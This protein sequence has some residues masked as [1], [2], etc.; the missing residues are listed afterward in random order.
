MSE[1][2]FDKI[3][4]CTL[5][6]VLVYFFNLKVISD[7]ENKLILRYCWSYWR[8]IRRKMHL[9]RMRKILQIAILFLPLL[10]W[11]WENLSWSSATFLFVCYL[12]FLVVISTFLHFIY[13]KLIMDSDS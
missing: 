3:F 6:L 13:I 10:C 5:L 7:W 2:F 12:L 9:Y 8:F 4:I 11:S 1:L